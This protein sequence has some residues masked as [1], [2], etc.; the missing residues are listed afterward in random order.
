MKG[1]LKKVN[2][3]EIVKK[4]KTKFK[5]LNYE[6]DV[7]IDTEKKEI[8]T[9]KGDM[10]IDYAKDY[11]EFCVN[12]LNDEKVKKLKDFVGKEVDVTLAKRMY[13]NK[14]G[15]ERVYNYIKFLNF[16]DKDGNPI[17]KNKKVIDI[18]F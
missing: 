7:V 2:V 13:T 17:F 15:E 9:Y 18:D 1:I 4:D 6:V 8:K 16:I 10:S 11:V 14:D 12:E 5:K 3:V